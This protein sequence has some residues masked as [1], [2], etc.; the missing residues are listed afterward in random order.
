MLNNLRN[1]MGVKLL[2]KAD[3]KI[4]SGNFND[5]KKGFRYIKYAVLIVPPSNE[6]NSFG[7]GLRRIISK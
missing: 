3:E 2:K 1:K 5:I 4:E 6:L 7:D